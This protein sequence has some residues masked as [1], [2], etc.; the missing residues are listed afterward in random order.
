MARKP[1]YRFDRLE[2]ERKKAAKK[3]A[4]LQAKR[5]AG[6]GPEDDLAA[7]VADTDTDAPTDP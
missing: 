5:D 7:P 2:R 1:N 3:A 4:K 6:E